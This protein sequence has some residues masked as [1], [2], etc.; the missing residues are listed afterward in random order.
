MNITSAGKLIWM[1]HTIHSFKILFKNSENALFF[2][3]FRFL[4][5]SILIFITTINKQTDLLKGF[6]SDVEVNINQQFI[7]SF[8]KTPL[9]IIMN[10]FL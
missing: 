1:I 6:H 10:V 8:V 9:T 7:L 2:V 4:Y 3:H 5:H